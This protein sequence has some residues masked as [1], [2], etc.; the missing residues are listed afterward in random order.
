[1]RGSVFLKLFGLCVL[2]GVLVASLMMPMAVGAGALVN[3]T[4]T[5]MSRMSDS[6]E[7]R[8][9]PL[10]T[11][12][13]DRNGDPMAHLFEDYRIPTP[14]DEIS[15]TMKAAI[16]AIEDKRFWDHHGV[17]W[18]GTMRALATNIASGSVQEGASTIT[19]QYVKNYLVHVAADNAVEAQN[20]KET[21]IA[22]KLREARLAVE[23]E[24]TMTK[25]EI[26]TGYLN[27]VPFGNQTFGVGAAA[28]TYFGTIPDKLTIAQSALLAALVNAPGALNPNTHPQDALHRRNLVIDRM[29]D[30]GNNIRI[31]EEDAERAKQQPLGVLSP[32][33]RPPNGCVSIGD[34][35]TDGFFCEYVLSYLQR[36]GFDRDKLETGGYTIRTTMDRKA[37]DAAKAAAEAQV[38]TRTPGIANAMAVV[39]PGTKKHEVRA[40]VANRDYGNDADKGQTAYPIV[41]D[42]QPFGAGS[43]FKIFTAAAALKQGMSIHDTIPTPPVYTSPIY[44]SGVRP[45]TVHNAE[46]VAPGP[47]TLQE[48]LATSPNTAFVMLQ[49]KVGLDNV[50]NMASELGLR[51]SMHH[52]D[53]GGRPLEDGELSEAQ[54]VKR[55]NMGSFTLGVSSVSVLELSNVMAT[56][57][58]DGTW[59]PPTPIEAVI[60]RNGN[61]V[62][63]KQKACEQVLSPQVAG[64][65]AQG[66]SKDALP[67]GT[68]H[69]PA[70][71]AGWQRPVAAKTGTTQRH[72]SAAFVGATPQM[73]GAV[74]TYA[75][76]G[77]PQGIC[78][79]GGGKPPFLCGD[80]N[81]NIYGGTVPGRTWFNAM[82]EIHEGLPVAPLS[83]SPRSP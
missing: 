80:G 62:P 28:Q 54:W 51:R 40:L 47:R 4:T 11:T 37:T 73:A 6:L 5:A 13:T 53:S 33:G 44:K 76:G 22:R 74:L 9:M 25:E 35:T 55:H 26:L 57:V 42:V 23:L 64:A 32:L 34:G 14:A 69:A 18:Q 75:D 56:I 27:V 83:S 63:V 52:V 21:T 16:T 50:V 17:D 68:A 10:T 78:V 8:Q 71:A 43:V 82:T 67:G 41:S 45:Y 15:K 7:K 79:R 49:E 19:Q 60:D 77:D 70:K 36:A 2:T 61:R 59:C 20:A 65:L 58:S 1:M 29:A 31:T 48:A 3:R 46:G 72:Q 30:P 81:G 38:P 39:E 12:I 66:L 24:R